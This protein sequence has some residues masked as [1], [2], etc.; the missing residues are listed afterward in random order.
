MV[1]LVIFLLKY[2]TK[3]KSYLLYLNIFICFLITFLRILLQFYVHI[4]LE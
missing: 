4:Q 3:E 2:I 1:L